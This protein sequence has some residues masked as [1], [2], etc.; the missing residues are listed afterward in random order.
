MNHKD[1]LTAEQLMRAR[2]EAFTKGDI[3]FIVGTNDP[4]TLKGLD[5]ETTKKWALESTW[6]GFEILKTEAG[7]VD[8]EEGI[9]EFTAKF[10]EDG[11]EYTH[12]EKSKFT[13][14]NGIWYYTDPMPLHE[15]I[16]KGKK[17]GANEQCPCGSEKKYKKCCGK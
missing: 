16:I 4:A 2:Y 5:V 6:L 10:I 14:I 8:D 9:V 17:I 1:F 13:K 3:D 12:H 15:T 7:Q 11:K